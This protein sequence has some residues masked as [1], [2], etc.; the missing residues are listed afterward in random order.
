MID[1]IKT[2][3]YREF[4]DGE[5]LNKMIQHYTSEEGERSFYYLESIILSVIDTINFIHNELADHF[6]QEYSIG[7]MSFEHFLVK[8]D[9]VLYLELNGIHPGNSVTDFEYFCAYILQS[10][11]IKT[12]DKRSL[13]NCIIG[14]VN[15]SFFYDRELTWNS[16]EVAF[17][18]IENG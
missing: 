14:Y 16:I 1:V 3:I 2:V 4:A 12:S 13:I 10:D 8:D 9:T 18:E 15:R 11:V 7:N 6:N 5:K 17:Q